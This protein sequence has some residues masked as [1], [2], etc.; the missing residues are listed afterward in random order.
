MDLRLISEP[1]TLEQKLGVVTLDAVK[2]QARVRH[3]DEDA[4]IQGYIASAFDFLHG[5]DG[6][7]NGY[8]LLEETF[9][10]FPDPPLEATTELPLRPIV[11]EDQVTLARRALGGAYVA[12]G[13]G[14]FMVASEDT[15]GVIARLSAVGFAPIR[16][17][18]DPREYQVTFKAGWPDPGLVPEPLK[19]AIRLLAA[20]F[21]VN[22]EASQ[23]T[24]GTGLSGASGKL[25][26]IEFGLRG[27]AG[28]YRVSPDHS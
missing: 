8:C 25:R 22:R 20:H 19:Q 24:G 28:R 26:E 2:A 15:F 4:L 5:P 1:L 3:D 16:S 21:Y 7:L 27:L 23:I 18:R 6:W 11:S 10:F 9:A 13:A 17:T 14:S 12:F